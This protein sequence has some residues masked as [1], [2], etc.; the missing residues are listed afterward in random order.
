MHLPDGFLSAPLTAGT[1]ALAAAGLIPAARRVATSTRGGLLLGGA[2]AAAVFAAQAANLPTAAGVSAHALGGA[3]LGALLGF[4]RAAPIVALV[5]A[6]QASYGD[7]GLLALGANLLNMAVLAPLVAALL[8][9]NGGP[10]RKGFAAAAG[11]FVAVA[12]CSTELVLSGRGPASAVFGDMLVAHVP[13]FVLEG[14]ATATFAAALLRSSAASAPP[15]AARLA[16]AAC[17]IFVVGA[18]FASDAPDALFAT[19]ERLGFAA[20]AR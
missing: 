5:V 8:G 17:A 20:T 2:A 11:T 9:R 14:L 18:V 12:A 1:A 15:R 16:W 10:A 4:R 19:A 3:T 6:V 7:G 13:I